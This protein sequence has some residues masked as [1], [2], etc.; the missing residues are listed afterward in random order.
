[1]QVEPVI[2]SGKYVSLEPMRIGHW[3]SLCSIGLEE[4]LWRWSPLK[5]S[6]NDE[7]REYVE[8]AIAD[9]ERGTALP[10]VTIE[11]TTGAIVGSTR[12]ANIDTINRRAEIGW[13]WINPKWQRTY[14]N[15]EAKLLMLR[16]AFETW[17]C[18][19]VELKTDALNEASRNAIRRLGAR[20]EGVF[21]NHMITWNGRFR[22]SVYFSIIDSEWSAVQSKLAERLELPPI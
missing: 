19:R 13:T 11:R 17:E 21:R 9:Q 12:F 18:I 4:S 14:V 15:T 6:N 10:F 7:M 5:I 3:P 2:L 20:E 16:H 8:T 1:M 22:D